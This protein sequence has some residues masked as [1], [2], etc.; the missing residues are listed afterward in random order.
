MMERITTTTNTLLEEKLC[1]YVASHTERLI[2]IVRELVRR[3]R[4][5]GR[6]SAR[7]APCRPA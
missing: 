6:A 4:R 1:S 7:P 3:S 5:L 2:G